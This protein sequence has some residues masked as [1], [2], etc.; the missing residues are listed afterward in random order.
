MNP[1][2]TPNANQSARTPSNEQLLMTMISLIE[3]NTKIIED[4]MQHRTV[5]EIKLEGC[6]MPTYSGRLRESFTLYQNQVDQYFAARNIAYMDPSITIRIIAVLGS[7][8]RDGAAQWYTI[9]QPQIQSV[10]QFFNE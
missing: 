7:S 2:N 8:L 6:P 5:A 9:R 10:Q 3:R 4:T 1:D